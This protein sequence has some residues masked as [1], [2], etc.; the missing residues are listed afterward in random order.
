MTEN[1]PIRE[2]IYLDLDKTA[3]LLSQLRGGLPKEYHE[4]YSKGGGSGAGVAAYV[5]NARLNSNESE[6]ATEIIHVHHDMLVE[7]ERL[8]EEQCRLIEISAEYG[9]GNPNAEEVHEAI[10]TTPY[11]RIEGTCEFRDFNM[12][13]RLLSVFA[14]GQGRSPS[15]KKGNRHKSSNQESPLSI[16]E[17]IEHFVPN[18]IHFAVQPFP[19]MIAYS[20]LKAECILD[21]DADNVLFHYRTKPT[22]QL[23]AFGVVASAPPRIV[24]AQSLFKYGE[25]AESNPQS[26]DIV[27]AFGNIHEFTEPLETIENFA[28]YPNISVYPYA[29][30]RTIR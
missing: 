20:N 14:R 30:Y 8:L 15:K 16:E 25:V 4:T 3:S 1:T 26:G 27:R 19:G 2:L 28:S 17:L 9:S 22:V 6:S 10:R 7:A 13:K 24:E 5:F 18:R 21:R 12:V 29:I 11:V 23:T